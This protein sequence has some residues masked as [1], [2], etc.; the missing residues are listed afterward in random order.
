MGLGTILLYRALL[1]LASCLLHQIQGCLD[2]LRINSPWTVSL[3]S[4]VSS[5]IRALSTLRHHI[6]A[7]T[8]ENTGVVSPRGAFFSLSPLFSHLFLLPDLLRL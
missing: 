7:I 8:S 3:S 2:F 5:S 4:T 1:L 6:A